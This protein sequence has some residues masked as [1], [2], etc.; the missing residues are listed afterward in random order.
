MTTQ[1]EQVDRWD[2]LLAMPP[3]VMSWLD[4]LNMAYPLGPVTSKAIVRKYPVFMKLHSHCWFHANL[5]IDC[6]SIIGAPRV[7]RKRIEKLWSEREYDEQQKQ[8]IAVRCRLEDEISHAARSKRT[9]AAIAINHIARLI[10][11]LYSDEDLW[12]MMTADVPDDMMEAAAMFTA[13]AKRD[14]RMSRAQACL[15]GAPM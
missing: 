12:Y 10:A 8:I 3:P 6:D 5:W 7:V 1:P 13:D 11:H 14:R 9:G 15:S 2:E 4:A